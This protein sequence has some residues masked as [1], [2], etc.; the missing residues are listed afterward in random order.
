MTRKFEA[1]VRR[2]NV[3]NFIDRVYLYGSRS[4]TYN[5][6][7]SHEEKIRRMELTKDSDWD[8]VAQHSEEASKE[9]KEKGWNLLTEKLYQDSST[10]EVF[11][12]EV[13]GGKI[14]ISLRDNYN[15]FRDLWGSISEE[16]YWKYLNKHSPTAFSKEEVQEY[17]DQLY[18]LATGHYTPKIRG[19]A[20]EPVP[21]AFN[22]HDPGR[23]LEVAD[24]P[25]DRVVAW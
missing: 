1:E 8:Y 3:F 7:T 25:Q 15:A 21:F 11:E 13:F 12:K 10:I 18:F 20:I 9:L 5:F 22:D 4:K 2:G 24:V 23:M 17:M 6:L 19:V 14:Q 16:F